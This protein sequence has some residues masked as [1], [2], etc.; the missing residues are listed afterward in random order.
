MLRE[1]LEELEM[2]RRQHE[3]EKAEISARVDELMRHN[4]DVQARMDAMLREREKASA[5]DEL[6]AEAKAA[7]EKERLL[8][9]AEWLLCCLMAANSF[10]CH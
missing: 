4:D 8:M 1:R 10:G 3:D 6:H 5:A 9:I 2:L 7:A